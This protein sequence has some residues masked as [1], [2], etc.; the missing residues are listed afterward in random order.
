MSLGDLSLGWT[1]SHMTLDSEESRSAAHVLGHLGH[2]T[3]W[4]LSF[5]LGSGFGSAP[6]RGGGQMLQAYGGLLSFSSNM[7]GTQNL[8]PGRAN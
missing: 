6:Y 7:Y 4:K 5:L 2:T 1:D 3:S 8:T